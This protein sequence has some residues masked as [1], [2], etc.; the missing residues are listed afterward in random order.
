MADLSINTQNVSASNL[1][2]IRKEYAFGETVLAGQVVYLDSATNRWKLFDTDAGAGAGANVTD[3]R[4]IALH[5]GTNGQPA[6]VCT[7]D[8]NFSPGATLANGTAYYGSKNAGMT[9]ADVPAASNYPVFLGL[10]RSTS[11]LNFQPIGAGIA[12]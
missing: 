6:A 5:N 4:G 3:M 10:A 8:P 7:A 11:R 9:T 12:V 1:A 2:N